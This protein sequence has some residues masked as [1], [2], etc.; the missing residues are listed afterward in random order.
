VLRYGASLGVAFLLI[1]AGF[2]YVRLA[3]RSIEKRIRQGLREAKAAGELPPEIDSEA[4]SLPDLGVRLTASA[5]RRIQLAH[6]LVAWRFV[7]IPLA[8]I[9]SLAI[10]R[11]LERR[12]P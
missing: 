9:V 6:L 11:I 8:L 4:A 12:R 1:A 3:E 2:L 7:L 5:M 10:A